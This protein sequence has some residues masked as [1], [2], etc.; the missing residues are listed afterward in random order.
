MSEFASVERRRQYCSRCGQ[1]M[2]EYYRSPD[3]HFGVIE[4]VESVLKRADASRRG[5]RC[6]Q[7]GARY[8]LLDRLGVMGQPIEKE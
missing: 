5:F 8:R 4:V 1:L 3:G 2:F 6:R 7:C